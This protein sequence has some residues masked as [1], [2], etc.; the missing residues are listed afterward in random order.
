MCFLTTSFLGACLIIVHDS[1]TLCSSCQY[2]FSYC[3]CVPGVAYRIVVN[4]CYQDISILLLP[5]SPLPF[6]PTHAEC[7]SPITISAHFSR[8]SAVRRG[9]FV[10]GTCA[11]A[12][13]GGS[14]THTFVL[15]L[16]DS[17]GNSLWAA[18]GL[19]D[20]TATAGCVVGEQV[21]ARGS[22]LV[23]GALR[24]F[25]VPCVLPR[26]LS[27]CCDC[28][29]DFVASLPSSSPPLPPLA[30]LIPFAVLVLARFCAGVCV[31]LRLSLRAPACIFEFPCFRGC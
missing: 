11:Y 24:H 20:A 26:P 29:S 4:A 3:K 23:D 1:L 8:S 17:A 6:G 27:M 10:A 12:V 13:D 21:F 9:L 14:D 22:L 28:V 2:V 25:Y 31:L 16:F 7:L 30:H 18:Q 5:Y 15:A 19:G